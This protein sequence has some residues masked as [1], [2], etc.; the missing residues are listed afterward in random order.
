MEAK[1]VAFITG[2]AGGIGLA[3]AK[4]LAQ[5]G[6]AIAIN[7]LR[8]DSLVKAVDEVKAECA[9]CL[10]VAGDISSEESVKKMV[11]DIIKAYG[12][13]DVLVNNAGVIYVG[14]IDEI[15]PERLLRTLNINVVSQFICMQAVLPYMKKQGGGKIINAA[16]QAAY[17]E[18]KYSLEYSTSKWAIRGMTRC[19][20]ACL[21]EYNISVNAYCPGKV[22][23]TDMQ[24]RLSRISTLNGGDADTYFE[25]AIAT[26]VPLKKATTKEDIAN[27]VA[28]LASP[29]GDII[30]GQAIMINGGEVMC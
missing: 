6:F 2:A 13:I 9:E 27:F 24:S 8:E 15:T 5:D 7:D 3:I 20:A 14:P 28:Y 23:Q 16:S 30:S 17:K 4:R 12:R 25:N 18:S 11:D 26:K 10:G 1:K 21:G 22:A 19:L 29:A